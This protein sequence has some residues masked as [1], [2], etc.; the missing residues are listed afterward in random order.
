MIPEPL[1]ESYVS[2][3]RLMWMI[4]MFDLPVVEPE[5]RKAATTFRNYL[6]DSGFAMSQYSIYM[7]LVNGKEA[8]EAVWGKIEKNLPDLGE[9]KCL[10]I[11]DKQYENI[12]SFRARVSEKQKNPDQ[13]LLF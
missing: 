10:M 13:L 11:T 12:K 5:E 1:G 9:V 3:Y 6:L 4:V 2:G 7:K 8:A